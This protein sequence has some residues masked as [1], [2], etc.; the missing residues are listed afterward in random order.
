VLCTREVREAARE[1]FQFSAAG[2]HRLKGVSGHMPLY[3]AR[4]S[5]AGEDQ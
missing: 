1:A 4:P 5:G 3:R 2:R